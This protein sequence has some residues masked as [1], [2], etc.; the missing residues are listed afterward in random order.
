MGA[1]MLCATLGLDYQVEH[2]ASYIASWLRALKD[3]KR[4]IFSAASQAQQALDYILERAGIA[5]PAE[6]LA[7]AA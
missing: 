3:D 4:F 1:S 6:E 7:E 5:E 2:H